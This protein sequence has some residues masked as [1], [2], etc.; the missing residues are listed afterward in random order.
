MC[1][2]EDV[3][4]ETITRAMVDL[5]DRRHAAVARAVARWASWSRLAGGSTRAADLIEHVVQYGIAAWQL[6]APAYAFWSHSGLD[7]AVVQSVVAF[8]VVLLLLMVLRGVGCGAWGICRRTCGF[9]CGWCCVAAKPARR[10]AGSK[11][12]SVRRGGGTTAAAAAHDQAP[13]IATVAPTVTAAAEGQS[14]EAKK[15]E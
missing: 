1:Q 10:P 6:P 11:A 2:S 14:L 3:S 7:V 12:R 4:R 8:P 5:L 13:A 15:S 9:C